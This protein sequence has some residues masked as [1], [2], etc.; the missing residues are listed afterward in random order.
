MRSNR[1]QQM[2]SKASNQG[3][4]KREGTFED[5]VPLNANDQSDSME[6]E[7]FDVED[8]DANDDQ[9]GGHIDVRVVEVD[10]GPKD[11][12]SQHLSNDE[13]LDLSQNRGLLFTDAQIKSSRRYNYDENEK[14]VSEEPKEIDKDDDI[15]I[16]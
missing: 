9:A 10:D 1:Q 14:A 4:S 12:I 15:I 11:E 8:D 5:V 3:G 13:E 16:H 7:A 6:F 2:S